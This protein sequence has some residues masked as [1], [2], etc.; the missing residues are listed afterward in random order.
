MAVF[1]KCGSGDGDGAGA[2]MVLPISQMNLVA[3]CRAGKSIL[4]TIYKASKQIVYPR[5]SFQGR[6]YREVYCDRLLF[7]HFGANDALTF[8][9]CGQKM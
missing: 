6:K 5:E 4:L 9:H 1:I 8:W 7:L 2:V 3:F